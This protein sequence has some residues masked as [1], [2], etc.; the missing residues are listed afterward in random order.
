[1]LFNCFCFVLLCLGCGEEGSSGPEPGEVE[2]LN[3]GKADEATGND[4]D[5]STSPSTDGFTL[6]F[7]DD[8]HD[9]NNGDG[10]PET[11]G[12]GGAETAG[13]GGPETAGDGGPET[14]GD[15]GSETAGDGGSEI[16]AENPYPVPVLSEEPSPQCAA[17]AADPWYFQYLDNLCN[18]KVQPSAQDRDR[19]CPV[20]DESPF[21][22]LQ[23]G[24]VVQYFNSNT[25]PAVDGDALAGLLPQGMRMIVILIKRVDGVPH[26]RY[27]SNGTHDIPM[28]PWSTTKFLAAANAAA[29]LRIESNYQVGL[30]ANVSGIPLGDLVTS[31]H[32]YDSSPY[33]SNSLGA[34]FHDIGG[35]DRAN[36]MIHEGWLYRPANETFGGNYGSAPPALGYTYSEPGG[37]TVTL[38]PD[39]SS[40]Y[41]NHLSMFTLAEA[42]KRLVLHIEEPEQRLPGI[43]WKDIRVLLFGA[44]N[45]AKYGVWGGM[46]A[47][48]AIYVQA[49]HDID[50]IEQRSHGQWTIFSKLG[51]GSQGQFMNVGY[52]CW[53]VL[54][55]NDDPVPGWGREF[56]IAAHLDQG[57]ANWDERDRL[58]AQA[59]RKVILRI[60]DGRL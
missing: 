1:M 37:A 55:G 53:P 27:I 54:D 8:S 12:D 60:V 14:A 50:Y 22:T 15:G 23:D 26:Y 16:S 39:L 58:M 31:V 10:G 20:A 25:T 4:A 46:T 29:F 6:P 35:R 41:S 40:G 18:E 5:T 19:A 21:A 59:Y 47:D 30:T 56:V 34:Y 43:Q 57:G 42:L 38:Q 45:S 13:D 7:F 2:F 52:A 44:E 51:L 49:G 36:D 3:P 9:E 32:N 24:S 28:Q 17:A 33:A 48:T 11:A